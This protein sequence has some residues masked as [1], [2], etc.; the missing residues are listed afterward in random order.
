VAKLLKTTAVNV[1]QVVQ[2]QAKK[3]PAPKK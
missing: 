3:K 2:Q 1:Q